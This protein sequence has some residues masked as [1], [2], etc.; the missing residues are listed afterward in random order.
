MF[1]NCTL[2]SQDKTTP[3][4]DTP[5]QAMRAG[6]KEQRLS[7]WLHGDVHRVSEALTA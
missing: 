1:R 3:E 5:C 7:D 6:N 4:G 2:T